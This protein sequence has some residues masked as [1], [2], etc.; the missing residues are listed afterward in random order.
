MGVLCFLFAVALHVVA[1]QTNTPSVAALAELTKPAKKIPFKEV[2]LATTQHR[3]L[4]FDTNNP[5]HVA[6]H[7]KISAAASAAAAKAR[8]D[9]LFS[10]RANEA[11]NHMETFVKA[12]LKEAG[13]NARTPVTAAGEAQTVGYPDVEILG[14]PPCYLELKTYSATT[15]NTTQRSFY[16][17]PSAN[18]KV[19][20]DALHLLLAYELEKTER[21][22]KTVFL[23]VHW[24]LITLQDLEVDLKFEFN[25]SNRG[26]Y[27]KEAGKALL[28]ESPVK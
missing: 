26:L 3:V 23:P 27:G 21:D 17:S 18:P 6:L 22:G 28:G 24:K 13:L 15:A 8:A 10:V 16:Y 7:K 19:T 4:D 11:G 12:A 2:I 25:Q 20:H 1:A 9:G 14:D 5:M